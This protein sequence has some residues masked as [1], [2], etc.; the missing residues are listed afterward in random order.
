MRVVEVADVDSVFDLI[1]S[2]LKNDPAYIQSEEA[3]K[4]ADFAI[5]N[6]ALARNNIVIQA[7]DISTRRYR[8]V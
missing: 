8:N 2:T 1:V 7:K 3:R 6:L 5:E 4:Y